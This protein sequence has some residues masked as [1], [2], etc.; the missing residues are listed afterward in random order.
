M[1]SAPVTVKIECISLAG[2][3]FL[4]GYLL[5]EQI[6]HRL[7][8]PILFGLTMA[9]HFAGLDHLTRGHFPKLYDGA[10]RYALAASVLVGW[11]AGVVLEVAG[12]SLDLWY[13][14]LA[15]G[16]IVIAAVYELPHVHTRKQYWAFVAGAG[17]FSLLILS[18]GYYEY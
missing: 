12:A 17:I 5:S 16:I 11:I 1:R 14:F 8:P 9:I 18:L 4:I 7:E 3:S 2:Y 15:G 10:L 6:T 13:S